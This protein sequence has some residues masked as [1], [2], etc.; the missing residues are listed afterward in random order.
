L[1]STPDKTSRSGKPFRVD[2]SRYSGK[3]ITLVLPDSDVLKRLLERDF[4]PSKTVILSR[5]DLSSEV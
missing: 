3:E 5:E 2:L 4:D 1:D